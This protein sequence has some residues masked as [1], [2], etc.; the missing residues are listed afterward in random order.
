MSFLSIAFLI[1][2]PL[3]AAP[4]LLHLFDRR[5]QVVISWGAMQFLAEAASRRTS[6]RKLKQWLLLFL[7]TAAVVALVLALARPML[8]GNWLGAASRTE[9]IFIVDNSMSM[10]RQAGAASLF[11]QAVQ[12]VIDEA[13]K[14]PPG[15]VVRV[16]LASPY[17]V[18]AT[19]GSLR[20][21]E[22]GL[23][24]LAEQLRGLRPTEARSD[25]L[26]ALFTAVQAEAPPMQEERRIV[27]LT[28]DQRI[29]WALDDHGGWRRFREVLHRASTPTRLEIIKVDRAAPDLGNVAISSLRSSRTVVGVDQPFRLTARVRNY[30]PSPASACLATWT[31]GQETLHQSQTPDLPVGAEHDM[32]W[33][34][35]FSQ[36]GVYAV[37]CRLDADDQLAPDNRAT[38]VVE[39]VQ[40]TPI[41]VVETAANL[42][43]VQQDAFFLQAALGW[44]DGAPV[45]EKSLYQPTLIEPATLAQTDL[46]QFR[47]V[48]IPS[49]TQLTKAAIDRLQQFVFDGGGLWIAL[50]PRTDVEAFNQWL[51]SDGAGLSPV[52]LEGIVENGQNDASEDAVETSIDPFL[53]DHPATVEL[54][55]HEQLDL[56]NVIVRQRFRF[57]STAFG[58]ETSVLLRL[59]NGEPL[60]VEKYLGRGR[61]IVQSIPMRLGWSELVRAQAFVV[62]VQDWLD[63]LS[64]PGATRHNL[65]PGEPISLH[66]DSREPAQATLRTPHGEEIE[67]VSEPVGDR[68][69]FRTSRTLLPGDYLLDVGFSGDGVPFHVQRDAQES[70]LAPRTADDNK[71]IAQLT[72]PSGDIAAASLVGVNHSDPLWPF[73]LIIL[74]GLIAAELLLSGLISRERFG[75]DP[76]SETT[77]HWADS[78]N[79]VSWTDQ[80]TSPPHAETRSGRERDSLTT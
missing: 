53:P 55:N 2:L 77:Q 51:F 3:A 33:R 36:P 12:R 41:L 17:P 22:G 32:V 34:H 21:G 74:I 26:A 31:I 69:M 72:G 48:V 43:D 14:A 1:A 15:D 70:Q 16:L 23:D 35:S 56:G 65:L 13:R 80:R 47:A 28:D 75:A 60:A 52:A 64:Q 61:I 37:S 71:L 11:E 79:A 66:L 19:N 76:I 9:T 59:N 54:A 42:T 50:G 7:R 62:M 39:A 68:L 5:R 20:V 67:L 38:V 40:Q 10:M 18:W 29:D 4:V 30:G 45:D 73:L 78:P 46:K 6:A 27:L 25:L 57:K 58:D 49:Y 63:Y 24:N 8:P 44:I